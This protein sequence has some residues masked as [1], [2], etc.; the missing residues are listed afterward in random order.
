MYDVIVVGGGPCGSAAARFCAESG[1][2]VLVLEE[3][4]SIGY[5][6]QC[7]GLLSCN[8]FDECRV[9]ERSVFQEVS[10]AKIISSGGSVLEFDSGKTKA[11]VVDRAALDREMA[12][13]AANAG[14]EFRL[15]SYVCGAENGRVFVRGQ[16]GREE[17]PAKMIIAADGPRSVL[18]RCYGLKRQEMI[19]SGA[20]A[21]VS[22]PGF[23]NLVEIYPGASEDFFGWVIP[24]GEGR[25]RVGLCG[26]ENVPQ[27]FSEFLKRFG[28]GNV[29]LVSGTIPLGVMPKTYH[30]RT[31]FV[32]DAAGFAK[33]TSGGGIYTGVRSA[34]HASETALE[35]IEKDSF[36]DSD[37]KRYEGRWKADFGRELK[38]GMMMYKMRRNLPDDRIDDICRILSRPDIRDD[39][40][41]YGDMDRPGVII[42]KVLKRPA[43]VKALGLAACMEIKSV[44]SS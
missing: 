41:K 36:S 7:A 44:F 5:P 25:A 15:K 3:H 18:S 42:R 37:L 27:R 20:Q 11:Y 29:H 31:L 6:V 38:I 9:T 24:A 2:K 43:V 12:E 35:C 17:I 13:N 4:A 8:A 21:E 26:G 28:S 30:D 40:I 14:A 19:L 10:G 33:P 1:L 34:F 16:S 39:I 23:H 32:G 22:F